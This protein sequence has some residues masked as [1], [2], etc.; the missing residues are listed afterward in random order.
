MSNSFT[1][2]ISGNNVKLMSMKRILYH[3][4]FQ[5]LLVTVTYAQKE[6]PAYVNFTKNSWPV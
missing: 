4:I 6:I 5:L 2:K 3:I 1:R